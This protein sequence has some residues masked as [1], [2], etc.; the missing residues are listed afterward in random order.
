MKTI[1]R[2]LQFILALSASFLVHLHC[3]ASSGKAV[4]ESAKQPEKIISLVPSVTE[5]IFALN[6]DKKLVGVSTYCDYPDK[7]KKITKAG[8]M[9]SPDLE[10]IRELQPDL[11]ILTSPVQ[12][13]LAKDLQN[14]GF[15]ILLLDDPKDIDGVLKQIQDVADALGAEKKGRLL[16]DSLRNVLS[17]IKRTDSIPAYIELSDDPLV[18]VGNQSFITHAL[19][20][21]GLVSI[22]CQSPQGYPIVNCEEIVMRS[23]KVV[24]LL[25]QQASCDEFKNRIGF[26]QLRAIKDDRVYDSLPIDELM[27]PA[28]R[29]V[30]GLI[31]VDSI[32]HYAE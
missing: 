12:K 19:S 31:V 22:F 14:L 8:D 32:V 25:Y 1:L 17:L 4:A 26:S 23:P 24:L 3:S 6:E 7:A 28:P 13:Q 20:Y 2:K 16:T 30:H 15:N 21:I 11:I 18:T 27:R 5:I 29:L 10:K 9:T